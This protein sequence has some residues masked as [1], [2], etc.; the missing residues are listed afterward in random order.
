VSLGAAIL[1][2]A[3]LVPRYGANGAAVAAVTAEAV[4]VGALAFVGRAG[5]RV[6]P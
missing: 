4:Q 3:A 6:S 5:G 1:L 2:F